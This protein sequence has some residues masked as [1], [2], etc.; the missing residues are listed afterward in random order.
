MGNKRNLPIEVALVIGK[1][2]A[3]LRDHPYLEYVKPP[4]ASSTHAPTYFSKFVPDLGIR[5]CLD[6]LSLV[7]NLVMV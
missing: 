4:D 5:G 7:Q 1:H 2:F 3:G 6:G